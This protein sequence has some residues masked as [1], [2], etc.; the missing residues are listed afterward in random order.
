MY[1]RP[2][3][4]DLVAAF[5]LWTLISHF[6]GVVAA[7]DHSAK[8]DCC[9][10]QDTENGRSA[11]FLVLLDVHSDAS[12]VAKMHRDRKAKRRAVTADLRQTAARSQ[13]NLVEML[14]G[15]NARHRPYWI[16][17]MIAAEGNRA[18][19]EALARRPDVR[20]I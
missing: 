19:V 16:V 2:K 20:A 8:I 9:V 13:M 3:P 18:F 5:V 11:H 15:H 14:R 4:L 10:W 12:A 17:N 6:S 1:A 7:P